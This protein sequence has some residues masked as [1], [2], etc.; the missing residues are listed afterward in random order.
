MTKARGSELLISGLA[1]VALAAF[2]FARARRA[3]QQA[4]AWQ[5]EADRWREASDAM[6]SIVIYPDG[7]TLIVPSWLIY[8]DLAQVWEHPPALVTAPTGEWRYG[9]LWQPGPGG[10]GGAWIDPATAVRPQARAA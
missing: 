9:Y 8:G 1:A 4:E 10:V 2:F 7:R 5:G 6:G 3:G